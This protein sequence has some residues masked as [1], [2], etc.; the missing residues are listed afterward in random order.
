MA[1]LLVAN[2]QGGPLAQLVVGPMQPLKH[3]TLGAIVVHTAAVFLCQQRIDI[4]Q[5]FVNMLKKPATLVVTA[6]EV[7]TICLLFTFATY[8]ACRAIVYL[9]FNKILCCYRMPIYQQCLKTSSWKL[10]VFLGDNFMVCIH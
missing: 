5:P 2:E 10:K 7:N 1:R 4:L 6:F 8:T 3:R 9:V